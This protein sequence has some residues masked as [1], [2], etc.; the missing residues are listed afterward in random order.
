MGDDETLPYPGPGQHAARLDRQDAH[1]ALDVQLTA[2][3]GAGI[4]E[5]AAQHPD[6]IDIFFGEEFCF[7]CFITQ[8]DLKLFHLVASFY[9]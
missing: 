3:P 6:Y 4:R 2:E 9:R 1:T 8:S 5:A 7:T